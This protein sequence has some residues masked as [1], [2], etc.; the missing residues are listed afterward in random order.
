MPSQCLRA[1]FGSLPEYIKSVVRPVA[2]ANL[3]N[4]Q[5]MG[6]ALHNATEEVLPRFPEYVDQSFD[7]ECRNRPEQMARAISE[8]EE[9]DRQNGE[10]PTS[11]LYGDTVRTSTESTDSEGP[12]ITVIRNAEVIIQSPRVGELEA[13]L[14]PGDVMRNSF[15]QEIEFIQRLDGGRAFF[16]EQE[17]QEAFTG[18]PHTI[19]ESSVEPFTGTPHKLENFD[20]EEMD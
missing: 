4:G 15:G 7:G 11:K 3:R 14:Q 18:T 12:G 8:I 5:C 20:L 17:T 10:T 16:R 9:E 19:D 2:E 1:L 6:G 13:I